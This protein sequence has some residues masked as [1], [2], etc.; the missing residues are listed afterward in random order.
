MYPSNG[1]DDGPSHSDDACEVIVAIFICFAARLFFE[2]LRSLVVGVFLK[3]FNSLKNKSILNCL[4]CSKCTWNFIYFFSSKCIFFEIFSTLFFSVCVL[5]HLS[6]PYR[7][8][9]IFTFLLFTK[10]VVVLLLLLLSLL[11]HFAMQLSQCGRGT[12]ILFGIFLR[13]NVRAKKLK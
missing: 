11:S 10:F 4:L 8:F 9:E 13:K 5:K 7:R 12:S 1:P 6:R 3:Y 2:K